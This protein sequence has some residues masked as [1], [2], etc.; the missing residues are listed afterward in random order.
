MGKLDGKVAIVTGSTSGMGRATAKLFAQEGARVVVT[1]RNKERGENVLKEIQKAGGD[2]IL[3]LADL[4][5]L[6]EVD[7]LVAKAVEAY[8]TVD[9]LIN[10]AAFY[11]TTPLQDLPLEEWRYSYAVNVTAPFY[12][13]KLVAPYMQK[14]GAGRIVNISSVAGAQSK[15]GCA[16]Y[17]ATKHAVLGLTRAMARELGPAIRTN[18][19]MP[20]AVMTPMLEPATKSDVGRAAIKAMNDDSNVKRVGDPAEVAQVNLFFASEDSSFVA[21][22]CIRVDG[23]LDL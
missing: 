17:A 1:G 16:A 21:G 12:L 10:N 19:V 14:S 9:V 23:G 8:G 3:A 18:C 5:K 2:A 4:S 13:C 11:S 22:Q 6:E 15:Y 20:G 7:N